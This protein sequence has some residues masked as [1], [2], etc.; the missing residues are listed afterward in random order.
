MCIQP[1]KQFSLKTAA[2]WQG[3]IAF[4]NAYTI[5]QVDLTDTHSHEHAHSYRLN[6]TKQNATEQVAPEQGGIPSISSQVVP[7]RVH[8]GCWL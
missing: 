5:C 2:A 7:P 4:E 8:H 3:Y 6:N 1:R